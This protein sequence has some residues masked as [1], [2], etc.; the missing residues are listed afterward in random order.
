MIKPGMIKA[1]MVGLGWWGQRLLEAAGPIGEKIQFIHAV[2]PRPD[3]RADVAKKYGLRLSPDIATML[4]DPEVQA[5][6]LAT[7][8]SM[9]ADQIEQVAA[10]G[11]PILCEKPFTLVRADAERAVAAAQ[12]AG[13]VLGVGHNRRFL[14]AVVEMKRIVASGALG[15]LLH[16]EG[17]LSNQ[18]S[19]ANFA[20]WRADPDESPAGGLTGTGVHILDCFVNLLGPVA[21]VRTQLV[22]WNQGMGK[23]GPGPLDSLTI[24]LQFRNGMSGTLAMIR[25]TPVFWRVHVFGETGS[26]ESIDETELRLRG[27]IGD[28]RTFAPVDTLRLELEAFADAAAGGPAYPVPYTEMIATVAAFEAVV[29][30]VKRGGAE[31]AVA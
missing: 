31:V 5:V 14:P 30:S 8:H 19:G 27:G 1:G 10:A 16:V 2:S 17:H 12:R 15:R 21:K 24:M 25:Q 3:V 18:N 22:Q 29:E 6:V 9:H 28:S 7:P 13:I 26:V 23:P 20:P 4:R 11:L